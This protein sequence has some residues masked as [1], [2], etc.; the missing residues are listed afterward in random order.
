MG[1]AR[2]DRDLAR[3]ERLATPAEIIPISTG[4]AAKAWMS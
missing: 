2:R 1:A 4:V 3:V